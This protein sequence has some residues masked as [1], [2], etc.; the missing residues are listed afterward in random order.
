METTKTIYYTDLYLR[1]SRDDGDKSESESIANQRALLQAFVA[2]NPDIIVRNI[3]VDDGYTGVNFDRPDFLAMMEAVRN[4]EI[5]CIIVKD[6]SRLGR[7]FTETCKYIQQI[8]PFLNVRFIAIND[9]YDSIRPRTSADNLVVPVKNLVNDSYCQDISI[10]IRSSQSIK[11]KSGQCIAPFAAFGYLKDPDNKNKLIVDETAAVIVQDVFKRKLDGW[12]AQVIAEQ[13][14]EADVL[15]PMEYKRWIGSKYASTFKRNDKALWT[16]VSVL[17]ILKNPL[18]IGTLIQGKRTSTSYKVKKRFNVSEDKWAVIEN[19]HEAIIPPTV[20]ENVARILNADTRTSPTED[21]VFPLSGLL[22]CG[23]CGKS[24]VRK[25]NASKCNPYYYYICSGY[26]NKQGCHSSHSIRAEL[27]E[28]AV[29]TALQEH[30][31]CV[32]NTQSSLTAIQKLP[33]TSRQIQKSDERIKQKREEIEKY[34]GYKLRLHEDY[35]DGL[36]PREDFIS[37]GARYTKKAEDAQ[38]A[39]FKMEK[40][41]E[42][43]VAG[44]SGEQ[45]WISYFKQ[46]ENISELNRKLAVE[47]ID[48]ITVFDE[49]RIEVAFQFQCE[50]EKMTAFIQSATVSAINEKMPLPR[51]EV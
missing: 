27:L 31:V 29:L 7:N 32:L 12:S 4:K 6:F 17:R 49:Q 45:Q 20:F 22:F 13:L 36:I 18:Y 10:K 51:Q 47:L 46:H 48:K 25:N 14:N 24:M 15:S 42:Q 11:R 37:F 33:Y 44:N 35:T 26:K 28:Q 2:E 1:I 8:F 16:A 41:I 43:L 38:Q 5:N 34:H 9:N 30:I 3:R 40:E 50:Y 39:I 19:S 23:D 21:I